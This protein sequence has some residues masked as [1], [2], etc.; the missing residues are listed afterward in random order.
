MI[1]KFLYV[2]H[3]PQKTSQWEEKWPFCQKQ[4]PTTYQTTILMKLPVVNTIMKKV[5]ETLPFSDIDP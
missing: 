1:S 5:T 4:K 3:V 2:K